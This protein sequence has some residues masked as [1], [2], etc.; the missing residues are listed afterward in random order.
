MVIVH[1][2]TTEH[3]GH[4]TEEKK[5]SFEVANSGVDFHNPRCVWHHFNPGSNFNS[6]AFLLLPQIIG[7]HLT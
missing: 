5:V 2:I 4:G 3:I 7:F 6:V 1:S